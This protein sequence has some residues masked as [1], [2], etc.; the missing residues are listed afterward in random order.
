[1]S[2]NLDLSVWQKKQAALLYLFSSIQYLEGLR[3]RVR[4]L[5]FVAEG[6]LNVGYVQRRDKVLKSKRWGSRNTVQNW[7]NN[8]WPFLGDFQQSIEKIIIDQRSNTYHQTGAYQCARGMSES[9]MQWMAP[10]EQGR[11]DK[12]FEESYRYAHYI[13]DTMDRTARAAGWCDFGLAMAWRN[14]MDQFEVLPKLR[15]R[16]DLF[17][18]SGELPPRTGVYVSTDDSAAALQFAWTGS[19]EG[20]LL[21]G[22]TFNDTGKAA[23]ATVGRAG[24]WTDGNAM[25]RFVLGNLSNPDLTKDPFFEESQTPDLAPSLVARN[26]FASHPSRWCYVE[27]IK[28]EFEPY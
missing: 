1:M 3:D 17:A 28:D 26:A 14:H 20:K 9:S 10:E 19:S 15:V 22:T 24:M 18:E 25:L 7:E 5:R 12:M 11:F 21:D 16:V 8:A 13:D 23:L 6:I 27:L 4:N 2:E